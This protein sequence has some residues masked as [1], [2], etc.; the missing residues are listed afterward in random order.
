MKN[1][2]YGNFYIHYMEWIKV[3][4]LGSNS[5][6]PESDGGDHHLGNYPTTNGE[7]WL[8]P[9][10]SGIVDTGPFSD[11][12]LSLA[13]NEDDS[14]NRLPG[15][16]GDAIYFPGA[17]GMFNETQTFTI[18]A[19]NI[20]HRVERQREIYDLFKNKLNE[21]NRQKEDFDTKV[22]E[23]KENDQKI[24]KAKIEI[25]NRPNTPK[26]P[27]P[28]KGPI[29]DIGRAVGAGADTW[30]AT[31][32]ANRRNVAYLKNGNTNMPTMDFATRSS[33]LRSMFD[34]TSSTGYTLTSA[35]PLVTRDVGHIFGRLGQGRETMPGD[36]N[37]AFYWGEELNTNRPSMLLSLFP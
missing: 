37:R 35:D 1:A 31:R 4:G 11:S 34:V 9:A 24:F 30:N 6:L 2:N 36:G 28:Y 32:T 29:L 27:G 18:D 23:D 14:I 5:Q 3:D 10:V 12:A 21:F 16:I 19:M 8:N 22:E 26:L 33:Y 17:P 25:P 7:V 20:M 15:S 13:F